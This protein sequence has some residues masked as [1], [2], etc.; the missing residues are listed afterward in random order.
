MFLGIF[1]WIGWRSRKAGNSATVR[2]IRG[3]VNFI[4]RKKKFCLRIGDSKI[5]F[6]V[7]PKV[8]DLFLPDREYRFYYRDIDKTILSL[9]AV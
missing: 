6:E 5:Q 2:S 8:K 7:E 4:Q 3:K 9:E 1:A